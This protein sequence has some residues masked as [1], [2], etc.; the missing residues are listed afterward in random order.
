VAESN[1]RER[2]LDAAL[3]L[4]EQ[5]GWD[6]VNLGDVARASDV[7][8]RELATC[9]RQKDDIAEAWFDR[10]DAALLGVHETPAWLALPVRDRLHR[11]FFAWF[12]AL[13]SH[14]RTT[15]Q[16]LRYKFHPE[17][18]HL[19]ALGVTR[20]SRTVQWLREAAALSSTGWRRELEEAALTSIFL[21]AFAHWLNDDSPGSRRTH[22]FLDGLLAA[23]ER[24][25]LRMSPRA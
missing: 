10:A 9:Y 6:A 17:H 24:A 23:A 2:I 4:A 22:T 3:E 16:M 1:V 12:E 14:R 5:R 21:A 7:T 18:I 25:A 20:I 19:Q 11:A 8:L 15:A 13:A